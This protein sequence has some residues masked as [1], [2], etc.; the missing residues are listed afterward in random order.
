LKLV[1]KRLVCA[2][3]LT[4]L[5]EKKSPNT[6]CQN[7]PAVAF[8]GFQETFPVADFG[9]DGNFTAALDLAN[10][11]MQPVSTVRRLEHVVRRGYEI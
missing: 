10:I 9:V 1:F 7:R 8:I 6:G 5:C 2:H 4:F 11:D 3:S